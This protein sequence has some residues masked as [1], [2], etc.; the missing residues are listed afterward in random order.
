VTLLD[1]ILNLA[2]LLLWL[3]WRSLKFDPLSQSSPSP[4]NFAGLIRRAEPTRIKPWHF[5]TALALLLFVRAWFYWQIGPVVDWTPSLWL[6]VIAPPFRSDYFSRALLY[7]VLSF[8]A[9][10]AVFYLWLLLFSIV[11]SGEKDAGPLQKLVRLHLGWLDRWWWPF[12]LVLPFFTVAAFWMAINPF[13]AHSKIIPPC[14]STLHRVEQA[15]TIG[16]GVYLSWQYVLYGILL[17]YMLSSY[18]FLGNHPFWIFVT[19]TARNLL[20]PVRFLRIGKLDFAPVLAIVA[21]FFSAQ[22]A[23]RELTSLYARLPI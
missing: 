19:A 1:S 3:N 14:A 5:L 21:T 17:L 8:G 15:A 18:V 12:K 11:N 10:L 2:A 16:L 4:V 23:Q 20:Y 7:S 9:V 6:G 22:F 13:L